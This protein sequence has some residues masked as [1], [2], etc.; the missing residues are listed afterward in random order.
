V[1]AQQDDNCHKEL[2]RRRQ[3]WER[4]LRGPRQAKKQKKK[5]EK[6]KLTL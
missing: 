5:Q 2:K 1:D 4:K 6:E 3:K